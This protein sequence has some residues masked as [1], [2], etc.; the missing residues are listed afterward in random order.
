MNDLK[1]EK[2]CQSCG[3]PL[4]EGKDSGT[5]SDGSKSTTYCNLCYE[6]GQFTQPNVT[7]DEMKKI[8][9]ES[10]KEKGWVWPLRLMA[11]WQLPRLKRWK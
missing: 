7:L 8:V 1:F 2:Q 11:K 10:L 5:E 6:K 4:K 3:M 9:D